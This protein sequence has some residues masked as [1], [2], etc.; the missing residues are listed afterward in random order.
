[1]DTQQLLDQLELINAEAKRV[2]RS[3]R[4]LK[5][6]AAQGLEQVATL[7]SKEDTR[8]EHQRDNPSIK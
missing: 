8:H 2:E 7:Q 6:L 3:A 1:M 5:K 4:V